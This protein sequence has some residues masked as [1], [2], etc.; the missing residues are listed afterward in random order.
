MSDELLIVNKTITIDG[1]SEI[2][3][4]TYYCF[5]LPNN[6]NPSSINLIN[7]NIKE[8]SNIKF[9]ILI[10]SQN[11]DNDYISNAK[12]NGNNCT[13]KFNNEDVSKDTSKYILQEFILNRYSGNNYKIFSKILYFYTDESE[14]DL[15]ID[16]LTIKK[17]TSNLFYYDISYADYYINTGIKEN[18]KIDINYSNNQTEDIAEFD[19]FIIN[20]YNSS[21]DL[22]DT[23]GN[24]NDTER[25]RGVS[26]TIISN[27]NFNIQNLIEGEGYTISMHPV[28]ESDKGYQLNFGDSF[29]LKE[30]Q[31]FTNVSVSTNYIKSNI[32]YINY[33][34]LS[35]DEYSSI[36][37][38]N[39]VNELTS[40]I[41]NVYKFQITT[42]NIYKYFKIKMKP[43]IREAITEIK[44]FGNKLIN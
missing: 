22:I 16:I 3:K 4:K 35:S 2:D 15:N 20:L 39:G 34:F 36:N 32:E 9:K 43:E 44:I 33:K 5:Y 18:N 24:E 8:N 14:F 41:N 27:N 1:S 7:L 29:R 10:N 19:N 42:P 13:I 30:I 26:K 23:S 25:E 38:E 11:M 17:K 31:F 40:E 37:I 6:E 21:G 12:I 28:I